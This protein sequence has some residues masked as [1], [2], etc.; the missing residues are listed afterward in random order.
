MGDRCG[1]TKCFRTLV[2]ILIIFAAFS[3]MV[4]AD[5]PDKTE[6]VSVSPDRLSSIIVRTD[7]GEGDVFLKTQ[8]SGEIKLF[9]T[10]FR[11]DPKIT[12]LSSDLAEIW[13]GTGSPGFFKR[14]IKV[15]TR[16]VSPEY[17][18]AAATDPALQKVITLDFGCIKVYQLFDEQPFGMFSLPGL[19]P[20]DGTVR[21]FT[22]NRFDIPYHQ[23]NGKTYRKEFKL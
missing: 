21:F 18:F 17:Y 16:A 9:N 23:S 8:N 5:V 2:L 12:W 4:C 10:Y 14:Y 20:W 1:I 15:S 3:G 19:V 6:Y 11:Y 22:A 7:L 13:V